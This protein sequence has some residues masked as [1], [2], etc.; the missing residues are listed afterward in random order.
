LNELIEV[1]NSMDAQSAADQQM[2]DDPFASD[3]SIDDP[4]AVDSSID[5][6]FAT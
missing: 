2:F 6:P 3:S 4:F 1:Q 5:D